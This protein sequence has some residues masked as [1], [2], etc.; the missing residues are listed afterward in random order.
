MTEVVSNGFAV[1][2][3]GGAVGAGAAAVWPVQGLQRD[4]GLSAAPGPTPPEQGASG[5]GIQQLQHRT[6]RL[7]HRRHAGVC[8]GE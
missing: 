5:G 2:A 7:Q 3:G 8:G 4:G 1:A 6:A